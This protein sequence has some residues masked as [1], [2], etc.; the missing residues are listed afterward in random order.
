[1]E[2]SL[3]DTLLFH[4]KMLYSEYI[5]MMLVQILSVEDGI[6][7]DCFLFCRRKRRVWIDVKLACRFGTVFVLARTVAIS[8]I[9]GNYRISSIICFEKSGIWFFF[10]CGI[11][12]KELWVYAMIKNAMLNSGQHLISWGHVVFQI[13]VGK[14]RMSG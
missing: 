1:M 13:F 9:W 4:G 8:N 12:L 10:S 5:L 14:T 6:F 11:F 2:F 7:F 3:K